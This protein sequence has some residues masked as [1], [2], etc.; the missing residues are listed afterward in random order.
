MGGYTGDR[1]SLEIPSVAFDALKVLLTAPPDGLDRVIDE[2]IARLGAGLNLSCVFVR[3]GNDR[4]QLAATHDWLSPSIKSRGYRLPGLGHDKMQF[5]R[6]KIRAGWPLHIPDVR[7]LTDGS[8]ERRLFEAGGFAGLLVLPI[9]LG[10][11]L[12]GIIGFASR[13]PREFSPDE[14][15]SLEAIAAAMASVVHRTGRPEGLERANACL[16]ATL[17]AI[18]DLVLELAPDGRFLKHQIG[19]SMIHLPLLEHVNGLLP[20]DVLP[21]EGAAIVRAVIADVD[22]TG[23][24]EGRTFYY[25]LP[26]ER[27]WYQISAAS[28]DEGGYVLVVQDITSQR[29]HLH[30]LEWLGDVARRTSNLVVVSD[31]E[32]RIEWVNPA[33]EAVSGWTLDEVR[34]HTPESVLH[35]ELTNPDTVAR[36]DEAMRAQRSIDAEILNRSRS[37]KIFWLKLKIQPRFDKKERLLGFISVATDVTDL[38]DARS[39]ASA[40]EQRA[41]ASRKQLASAVEALND[42]FILFDADDRLVLTNSRYRATYP[43]TAPVMTEGTSFQDI[44]RHGVECGDFNLTPGEEKRLVALRKKGRFVDSQVRR[45]EDGRVL[46]IHDN[47]T[48]DGGRVALCS[49]I[50]DL[51]L[52]QKKLQAIV[53][54]ASVGT[55]EWT[56]PTGKNEVNARWAEIIGYRLNEMSMEI[57]Q[58]RALCHADDLRRMD[59][60]LPDILAGKRAQFDLRLRMRHKEGHWVWV[61]SRGR[62]LQRD[63]VGKP[64][65]MSGI[66]MDITELVEARER[67]E[68]ASAAKSA[69]LAAMSHEIR[70]PLNSVLGMADILAGTLLHD[71]QRNM[72]DTIRESGWSLL[73]VLDDILDL[74]RLEAG[75]L[76][77]EV[78]PFDLPLLLERLETL[79]RAAAHSKGL[80][81]EVV[82][83][84]NA[85]HRVG[86][87]M[88]LTQI[89]QNLIGNA[90]KFTTTGQVRVEVEAGSHDFVDFRVTDTGIGMSDDA[91]SRVFEV[92][93]QADSG[94]ARRYGGSG[95]GLA[96]VHRLVEQ[97]RG[98][99]SV[100]SAP[101]QGTCFAIRLPLS[102]GTVDI[103]HEIGADE[104][105]AKLPAP[106]TDLVGL[107]VLVAEDNATNRKILQ[108]MLGKLGVHACFADDGAQAL[109]LWREQPFDLVILDISMPVIDGIEALKTMQREAKDT[110]APQ[111]RA[112]AATAN[113]MKEQVEEYRKAGFVETISKPIRLEELTNVLVRT[114]QIPAETS[115][116]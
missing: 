67:A 16:K 65:L 60:E 112:I 70:T 81:F 85:R 44:L 46:R 56:I 94:I 23:S 2:T 111:P 29:A 47:P 50:T 102:S 116:S 31:V 110:G 61:L 79:H 39:A 18:P 86:D 103:V 87:P 54:G 40:A 36:I 53:E 4:A 30:E 91:M 41:E 59:A 93:Q 57:G 42:G 49:D 43:Q 106:T 8:S 80:A 68:A 51:T 13:L 100:T 62:V 5:W 48:A 12:L 3:L 11:L 37:G 105:K 115:P 104:S 83:R 76:T 89:L 71:D 74:S 21:P 114:N 7:K 72:L 98:S 20:E 9:H 26:D 22:S 58:F 113:V 73:A 10:N 99:V 64:V 107:R 1:H 109:S 32:G 19:R 55:W 52:A 33:F 78:R 90:I 88:R 84:G 95:L 82:L 24:S 92:F 96:I 28:H 97:M 45:F 15:V 6:E 38:I 34:G 101:G 25:D 35:C 17:S 63:P 27:R 69:F 108:I 77:L 66:H 14:I 75:K